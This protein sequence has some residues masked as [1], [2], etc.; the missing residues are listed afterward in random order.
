MDIT[1]RKGGEERIMGKFD[2]NVVLC[3][4]SELVSY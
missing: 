2:I 3:I 4:A 1:V